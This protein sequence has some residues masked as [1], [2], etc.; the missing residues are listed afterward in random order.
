MRFD[1]VK[2]PLVPRLLGMAGLVPQLLALVLIIGNDPQW[3]YI[4]LASAFGY[5]AL[6]FSFLGGLWWGI[7]AATQAAGRRPYPWLY[8]AAVAPSLIA[9]AAYLP[10]V[11]G[12]SW[13]GPSLV[14][15]GLCLLATPLVDRQIARF[16]PPWWLPLRW[17]LSAGLGLSTLAIAIFA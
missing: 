9:F 8:A 17:Q 2:V 3:R 6:I 11:F 13:P 14:L 10:W 4:A 15:L 1:R 7:A 5:A 12:L 16:V